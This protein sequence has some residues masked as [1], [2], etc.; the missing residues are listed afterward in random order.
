MPV[1]VR[2]PPSVAITT[3]TAFPTREPLVGDSGRVERTRHAVIGAAVGAVVGVAVGYHRGRAA[4]RSCGGDCGGPAGIGIIA[5]TFYFGFM[6][7]AL[8]A[9]VGY[10]VSP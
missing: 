2:R 4:D 7:L 3:F 10:V 5:D 1:G 9:I 8:G 6:G